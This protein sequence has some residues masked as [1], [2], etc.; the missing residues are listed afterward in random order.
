MELLALH[1]IFF[2]VSF[3]LVWCGAGLTIDA[4]SSLASQLKISRFTLSFF[5]LGMLTSMP[6]IVIGTFSSLGGQPQVFVG[7]LLGGIIVILLFV[8]PL[9]AI[10]G[11]G[12]SSPSQISRRD[13]LLI[14]AVIVAPS[15]LAAD[16]RITATDAGIFLLLYA[17]LFVYFAFEQ[18]IF[19]KLFAK[20]KSSKK[21]KPTILFHLIGGVLMLLFGG[22]QIVQSTTFFS[23]YFSVSPFF[24]SL[25][26]VALGTNIPEI[27]LIFRSIRKGKKDIAL[28]DYLGSATANV[29]LLG[30]F[31]FVFGED[32]VLPNHFLQRVIFTSLGILLFF[33]FSGTR[34]S[35]SRAEGIFLLLLYFFFIVTESFI[36]LKLS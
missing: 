25:I 35:I 20:A 33:R 5:V 15:L 28:A 10:F 16:Q 21:I 22:Y 18:S 7:N 13:L 12:V 8:I 6:E 17:L 19:E 34:K 9:L 30:I 14:L 11:N 31:T 3:F 24:V 36:A 1:T 29:P 26:A 2:L 27:S 32:I 23:N 4:I